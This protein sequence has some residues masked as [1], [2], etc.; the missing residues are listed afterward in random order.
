MD[1][2]NFLLANFC[3]LALWKNSVPLL[4]QLLQ[5][6]PFQPVIDSK[7]M[8]WHIYIGCFLVLFSYSILR[9]IWKPLQTK[10]KKIMETMSLILQG[11]E[12]GK[13]NQQVCEVGKWI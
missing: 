12:R 3:S 4:C 8:N 7:S 5:E 2:T 6:L 11:K 10:I 9:G 1:K 13:E